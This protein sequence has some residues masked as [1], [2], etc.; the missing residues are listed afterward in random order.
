MFVLQTIKIAP[1]LCFTF[2]LTPE[3]WSQV[4]LLR[5][6]QFY[7]I[8]KDSLSAYYKNGLSFFKNV[9]KTAKRCKKMAFGHF[10]M[11]WRNKVNSKSD[12]N[13]KA[14]FE[15]RMIKHIYRR[16]CSVI[17][18]RWPTLLFHDFPCEMTWIFLF[19]S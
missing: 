19:K 3:C 5:V 6:R 17:Y 12:F 18:K 15:I 4:L 1:L 16:K 13:L 8:F 14:S 7:Q 2:S 10:S 9:H 11:S